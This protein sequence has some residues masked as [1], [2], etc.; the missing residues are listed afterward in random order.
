MHTSRA[1]TILPFIKLIPVQEG[2]D[3]RPYKC[4]LPFSY[5]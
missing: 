3:L 1:C 5:P 2:L 4:P